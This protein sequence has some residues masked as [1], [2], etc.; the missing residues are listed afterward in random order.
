MQGDE[1]GFV[2]AVESSLKRPIGS[3]VLDRMKISSIQER[4]R[5]HVLERDNRS[6]AARIMAQRELSG[7]GEIFSMYFY[8]RFMYAA[9]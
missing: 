7:E 6:I 3:H 9:I 2:D 8:V 5:E 4:L 1:K